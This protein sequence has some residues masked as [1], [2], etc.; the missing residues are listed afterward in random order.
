MKKA[1]LF[2]FSIVI[3]TAISACSNSTG[4][5]GNEESVSQRGTLTVSGTE[6]ELTNLY[7]DHEGYDSFS[8]NYDIDI[9][10]FSEEVSFDGNDNNG[11]TDGSGVQ[12]DMSFPSDE[13]ISE[14]YAFSTSEDD[15]TFSDF[16]DSF[17]SPGDYREYFA[18]G[19]LEITIDGGIYTIE[20]DM[21]DN[22]GDEV[23]FNYTGPV[24]EEF[25]ADS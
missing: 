9:L 25:P 11:I 22:N 18:G 8:N 13:V 1:T 24:T 7:I 16:S 14:T 15:N 2:I 5:N 12:L 19:S 6:Y 4:D 20:G 21:T 17:T 10:I 23:T 3:V